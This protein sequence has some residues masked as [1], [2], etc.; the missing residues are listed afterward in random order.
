MKRYLNTAAVA[1]VAGVAVV[2]G[3]T[4][5]IPIAVRLEERAFPVIADWRATDWYAEGNDLI[6]TGLM[7]KSRDCAYSPPPGARDSATG[8]NY[9]VQSMSRTPVR[10]W[11]SS[12]KPQKFGPWRVLGGA[13]KQI[14]FYLEYR[15]HPLW[16]TTELVGG[17][18]G[19]T[20]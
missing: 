4:T 10:T 12:P 5:A 3:V 6:V 7:T 19:T 16:A 18:D 17:V 8:V 20:R 2:F 1:F 14:E 9:L 11:D 15:C 13:G